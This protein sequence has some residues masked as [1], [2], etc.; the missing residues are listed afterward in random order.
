M[1]MAGMSANR[2]HHRRGC[3]LT[4]GFEVRAGHQAEFTPIDRAEAGEAGV[5]SEQHSEQN[6]I[7]GEFVRGVNK[8]WA[9]FTLRNRFCPT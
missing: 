7:I 1:F 4:D 3:R 9:G 5:T 8:K 6:L 2:T